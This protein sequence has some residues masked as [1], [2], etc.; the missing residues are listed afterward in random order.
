MTVTAG[1]GKKTYVDA[2][3]LQ[4]SV[5]SDG[6][7]LVV[8]PGCHTTVVPVPGH[9]F[10]LEEGLISTLFDTLVNG[11]AVCHFLGMYRGLDM[12][13]APT[14]RGS[15]WQQGAEPEQLSW[16][17]HKLLGS[18]VP[19]RSKHCF[20]YTSGNPDFSVWRIDLLGSIQSWMEIVPLHGDASYRQ[21]ELNAPSKQMYRV[22]IGVSSYMLYEY[23]PTISNSLSLSLVP[24][25]ST[26]YPLLAFECA[27]SEII[28]SATLTAYRNDG[29]Y[30][31]MHPVS[32]HLLAPCWSPKR[33]RNLLLSVLHDE[34]LADGLVLEELYRNIGK[35][36]DGFERHPKLY[37]KV[38]EWVHSTA[39]RIYKQEIITLVNKKVGVHFNA[40]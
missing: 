34:E 2:P 18:H 16:L 29:V 9:L 17:E 10:A 4:V 11:K 36:L 39:T 26:K 35:I 25:I 31:R 20:N 23:F 1:A 6:Q 14:A 8:I 12:M 38:Q 5:A 37:N 21:R 19:G 33:V 15:R 27:E 7:R 13:P 24:A 28:S 30:L 22:S 3:G 40:R 32:P